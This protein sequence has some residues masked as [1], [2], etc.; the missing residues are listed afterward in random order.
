VLLFVIRVWEEELGALEL[1]C[2]ELIGQE[3]EKWPDI[4][5]ILEDTQVKAGR[6]VSYNIKCV[7]VGGPGLV[8]ADNN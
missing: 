5:Q 1:R 2:T 6:E 4:N 8:V 3:V 7:I